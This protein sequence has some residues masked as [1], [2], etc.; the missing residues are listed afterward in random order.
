[1]GGIFSSG[2]CDCESERGQMEKNVPFTQT[3]ANNIV[4]EQLPPFIMPSCRRYGN[5]NTLQKDYEACTL[6]STALKETVENLEAQYSSLNQQFMRTQSNLRALQNQLT[7]RGSQG[8]GWP[9]R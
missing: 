6:K 8:A 5:V 7:V 2:S 9:R 3:G 4:K 1:M